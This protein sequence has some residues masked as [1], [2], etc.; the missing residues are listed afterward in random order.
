M[1]NNSK[2][3]AKLNN[4]AVT[5]SIYLHDGKFDKLKDIS[6]SPEDANT[7]LKDLLKEFMSGEGEFKAQ[8]I[9]YLISYV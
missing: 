3:K 6:I 9:P 4:E 8:M 5:A 7:I 1:D 2:P